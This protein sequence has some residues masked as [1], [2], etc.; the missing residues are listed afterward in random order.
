MD[1]DL[2]GGERADRNLIPEQAK[3]AAYR[4]AEEALTNVV[5]HANVTNVSVRLEAPSGGWF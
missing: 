5:K 4:I 1:E 3:S 2:V